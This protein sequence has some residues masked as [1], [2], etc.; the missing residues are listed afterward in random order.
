MT[1]HSVFYDAEYGAQLEACPSR[2][3]AFL[4]FSHDGHD[5]TFTLAID[6]EQIADLRARFA[7]HAAK[8]RGGGSRKQ[9]SIV[10]FGDS[11]R[12]TAHDAGEIVKI[13]DDLAS[14]TY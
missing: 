5:A 3:Y 13:L 4:T 6:E 12:F 10:I 7:A 8:V 11:Y 1:I 9:E 2:D 14:G